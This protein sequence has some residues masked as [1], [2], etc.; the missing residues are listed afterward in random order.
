MPFAMG[1]LFRERTGS[2]WGWDGE[3]G[4]KGRE[5]TY[6]FLPRILSGSLGLSPAG[7][8]RI[9]VE[10]T[11]QSLPERAVLSAPPAPKLYPKW[12][13]AAPP[14]RP[15]P[16]LPVNGLRYVRE[17]LQPSSPGGYRLLLWIL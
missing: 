5:G 15:R 11:T 1:D 12:S 4:D 17:D 13:G 3:N 14:G 8:Y 2:A 16:C 6:M 9:T 7:P 10:F